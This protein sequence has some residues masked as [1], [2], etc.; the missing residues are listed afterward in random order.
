MVLLEL[1]PTAISSS[2][3]IRWISAS[4]PTKTP[5]LGD[6]EEANMEW[7]RERQDAET[8]LLA[9][10]DRARELKLRLQELESGGLETACPTCE[11]VLAGESRLS[12]VY[13]LK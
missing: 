7:L 12:S 10:R 8:H 6:M 9:Y 5:L 3:Q 1:R 2:S 13:L 4:S 11:R